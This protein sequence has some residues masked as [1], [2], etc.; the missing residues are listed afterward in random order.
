MLSD[1]VDE[2]TEDAKQNFRYSTQVAQQ[3]KVAIHSTFVS[4]TNQAQVQM[5][6]IQRIIVIPLL[7]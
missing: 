7:V 1:R 5:D 4:L 3:V 2:E 6:R